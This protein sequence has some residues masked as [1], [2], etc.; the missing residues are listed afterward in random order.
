M[1]VYKQKQWQH[2]TTGTAGNTTIFGVNIFDYEW[3]ARVEDAAGHI[4]EGGELV[5]RLADPAVMKNIN[6]ILEQRPDLLDELQETYLTSL[7]GRELI[8]DSRF[9]PI[10]SGEIS[11]I[12]VV[13]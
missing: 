3:N 6:Y 10:E 2:T 8:I 13:A 5:K 12:F 9:I 11:R 4:V 1:R 7:L